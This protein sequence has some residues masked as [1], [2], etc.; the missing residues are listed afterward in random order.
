[1]HGDDE[2][3]GGRARGQRR[4]RAVRRLALAAALLVAAFA[5]MHF[6][7]VLAA[8]PFTFDV[9]GAPGAACIVVPGAR[10]HSD[11]TPFH[12]LADRLAAA[13]ALWRA[14]KAPRIVLS[15]RGGGG[16]GVDEVAA[17]RRWLEARGVPP[18][19]LVDDAAG[20][21][22]LDTL[23]FCRE[24]HGDA[25]VLLVSNPFHVARCVFLGRALG[26]DAIG[27]DAPYDASYSTS[28]MARNQGRE[29]LARI[30]A[31]LDVF[32]LGVAR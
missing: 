25:R 15:G 18:A 27:V 6:H 3:G 28:T 31:W 4:W 19:A 10:I 8:R 22:T 1:M 17:M 5:A 12:L 21:R 2:R 9:A 29:V 11:G 20:L 14:D 32:V 13:L 16:P 26:L 23:R 30:R 24:R 7:V